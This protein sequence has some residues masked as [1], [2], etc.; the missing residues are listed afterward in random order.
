VGKKPS[1]TTGQLLKFQ[2]SGDM[3]G[4]STWAPPIPCSQDL[5]LRLGIVTVAVA[6]NVV[7]LRGSKRLLKRCL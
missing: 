2:S 1:L 7:Q 3:F 5:T 4:S 6:I